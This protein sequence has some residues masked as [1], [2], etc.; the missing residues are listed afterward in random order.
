MLL[1]TRLPA[2]GPAAIGALLG[3]SGLLGTRDAAGHRHSSGTKSG[4]HA[5]ATQKI[6]RRMAFDHQALTALLSRTFPAYHQ[7]PVPVGAADA[8]DQ[9]PRALLAYFYQMYC[10]PETALIACLQKL[11]MGP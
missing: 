3:P 7:L 9:W 10:D 6:L 2:P 4:R 5:G 8:A 11:A 1:S